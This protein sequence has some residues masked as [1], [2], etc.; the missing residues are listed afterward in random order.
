MNLPEILSRVSERVYY[1]KIK[2][3]TEL[4]LDNEKLANEISLKGLFVKNM[5]EKINNAPES[6]RAELENALKLG[7]RAFGAEVAYDE[8]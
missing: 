1:A 5:L 3:K 7:L 8:D 6:E 2:D 4:L